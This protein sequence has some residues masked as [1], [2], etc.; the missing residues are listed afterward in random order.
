MGISHRAGPGLS[1]E[2]LALLR[3]T[4]TQ[5]RPSSAHIDLPAT[6]A[7]TEAGVEFEV[8]QPW[9]NV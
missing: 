6:R 5:P 7:R 9:S 4:L 2:S 3:S 1:L 8:Q